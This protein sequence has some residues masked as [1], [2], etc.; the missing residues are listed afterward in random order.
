MLGHNL[1]L[2]NHFVQLNAWKSA[3]FTTYVVE[4]KPGD[5]ILVLPLAAH[6]KRCQIIPQAHD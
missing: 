3:P 6:Q 1:D 5:L 2:E 4:Q